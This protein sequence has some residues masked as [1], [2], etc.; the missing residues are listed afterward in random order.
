MINFTRNYDHLYPPHYKHESSNSI[1]IYLSVMVPTVVTQNLIPRF[2]PCAL[3]EFPL[4]CFSSSFFSLHSASSWSIYPGS[5]QTR[6]NF[7]S[8]QGWAWLGH[9][10]YFLAHHMIFQERG[11]WFFQAGVAWPGSGRVFLGST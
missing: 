11:K 9:G 10:G 7:G 1:G 8:N 2:W 3:T 5:R 4:P 6:V